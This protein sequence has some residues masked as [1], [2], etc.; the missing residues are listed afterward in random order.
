MRHEVS[1]NLDKLMKISRKLLKT[2]EL[3]QLFTDQKE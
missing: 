2:T 3:F 1:L